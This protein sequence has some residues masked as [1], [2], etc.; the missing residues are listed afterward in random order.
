[1]LKRAGLALLLVIAWSAA[2]LGGTL[3]G[4][5]RRPLA[6]DDDPGAFMR[7]AI[8]II[9]GG[10][11]ANTALILIERGAISAEY[12]S[13]NVDAIDRDTVFATASLSK[14]ITAHAVMKLVEQGK[15]DL[16]RPVDEQITRWHLPKSA[17]DTRGVTARRL[18]SHTAGLSDGLGFGDYGLDETV[19]TLWRRVSPRR[20]GRTA[21][22]PPSR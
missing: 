8:P 17:F 6:P 3:F 15:L 7:A 21:P 1:M 22:H 9:S 20:A 2:L 5:W 12:Y 4:W 19:P 14:W 13:A 16:D 10:N 11:R 18:L